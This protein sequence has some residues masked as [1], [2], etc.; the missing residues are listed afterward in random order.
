MLLSYAEIQLDQDGFHRSVDASLAEVINVSNRTEADCN[1]EE[2]SPTHH[3]NDS[4]TEW[5]NTLLVFHK[6]LLFV[7]NCVRLQVMAEALLSVNQPQLDHTPTY[8]LFN[9]ATLQLPDSRASTM[10]MPLFSL[11]IYPPSSGESTFHPPI[12][13]YGRSAELDS[14]MLTSISR[15]STSQPLTTANMAQGMQGAR[16]LKKNRK[17]DKSRELM[18]HGFDSSLARPTP[19]CLTQSTSQPTSIDELRKELKI[20]QSSVAMLDYMLEE[21]ITWVQTNCKGTSGIGGKTLS[22]RAKAQCQRM[23]LERIFDVLSNYYLNSLGKYLKRW[24]VNC[25]LTVM[26]A[27]AKQYAKAKGIELLTSALGDALLRNYRKM[28]IPWM[29]RMRV[30]R[31]WE[32]EAASVIMQCTVRKKLA[33]VRVQKIRVVKNVLI[34]QCAMRS[35][36][37][38]HRV[39][40]LRTE[41][42]LALTTRALQQWMYGQVLRKKA[43]AKV[44]E[45]R[46]NICARKIQKVLR[47]GFA[48][49][50]VAKLRALNEKKRVAAVAIQRIVRGRQG[51]KRCKQ[52]KK[53]L[54]LEK[55][56]RAEELRKKKAE[57]E[58]AK[59][60][61]EKKAGV[62]SNFFRRHLSTKNDRENLKKMKKEK[63]EET[64]KQKGAIGIQSLFR[65]RKASVHVA[66][67]KQKKEQELLSNSSRANS[68]DKMDD[69]GSLVSASSSSTR[70][71][72]DHD[73]A[74]LKLQSI[75]RGRAARRK[76]VEL[77]EAKVKNRMRLFGGNKK[78]DVSKRDATPPKRGF[79]GRLTASFDGGNDRAATPP[80]IID[81]SPSLPPDAPQSSPLSSAN[82][83]VLDNVPAPGSVSRPASS[84][85]ARSN[86]P[87]SARISQF[88]GRTT[89]RDEKADESNHAIDGVIV[90]ADEAPEEESPPKQIPTSRPPSASPQVTQHQE[91]SD[92]ADSSV[93]SVSRP[94]SARP[95]SA[96]SKRPASAASSR[97]QS[98]AS[99]QS[100]SAVS[101]PSS[102]VSN[103][104]LSAAPHPPPLEEIP[105]GIPEDDG[106]IV[107][108]RS[109]KSLS[110][111][112]INSQPSMQDAPASRPSSSQVPSTRH[113]TPPHSVPPSR[114]QSRERCTPEKDEEQ[115]LERPQVEEIAQSEES[116]VL[117][118][119]LSPEMREDLELADELR[120]I[121]THEQE[122]QVGDVEP[123]ARPL[124]T[125]SHRSDG[126]GLVRQ[127]SAKLGNMLGGV[128]RPSTSTPNLASMDDEEGKDVINVR[129]T[130]SASSIFGQLKT[131]DFSRPTTAKS[132]DG[133]PTPLARMG[134]IFSSS[135]RSL[136]RSI[137]S[138]AQSISRPETPADYSHT[139]RKPIVK[140]FSS[141]TITKDDAAWH[142]QQAV[143]S[144][145]ARKRASRR[146]EEVQNEQRIAG[147]YVLWAAVT[148]Q[149]VM[150]GKLGRI[151]F[152]TKKEEHNVSL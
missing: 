55:R 72:K 104:P 131:P 7:S 78:D 62:V 111:K 100:S 39:K 146:R 38:R 34:I 73:E 92:R 108:A 97:P 79:L 121:M 3:D 15:E 124:S 2:L 84:A 87:L 102:A 107:S 152:M 119:R 16:N 148:V 52:I 138:A 58:E 74:A 47:G 53:Q 48:R 25:K 9:T 69:D 63:E 65:K 19:Q 76:S 45:L 93:R 110:G 5:G 22:A 67:L 80:K 11:S 129:P 143:R 82:V 83:P 43:V 141:N 33:T 12:S 50:R 126:G 71:P 150:R 24:S 94:S 106:S 145:Q 44:N 105:S 125:G 115:D 30:E 31:R 41:R 103:R 29:R 32:Q 56:Q 136:G 118:E 28:F 135:M 46:R 132:T 142:I 75:A 49:T 151:R 77:K 6:W 113:P 85:S 14:L 66:E 147:M 116:Q 95:Q 112:H 54:L 88:F 68:L 99:V 134:S 123:P 91:E 149:R 64:R 36:R 37:A 57:E 109:S 20:A 130:R 89:D 51:R 117:H 127:M 18:R 13:R 140:R 133:S 98:A 8:D 137:S 35:A 10:Q 1:K 90:E 114:A 61:K 60:R 122:E 26:T 42:Q 81:R 144:R 139:P 4:S 86:A 128:I 17:R 101:R 23:A 70:K 40:T 59:K 27:V 120:K 96:L 21:N